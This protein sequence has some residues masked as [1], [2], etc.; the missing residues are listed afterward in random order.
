[1]IRYLATR[2]ISACLALFPIGAS[3]LSL[4]LDGAELPSGHFSL[5]AAP[6]ETIAL[7][8][9]ADIEQT[10][11]LLDG[12]DAGRR[13]AAQ[14]QVVA[15]VEPGIYALVIDHLSSSERRELSLYVGRPASDIRDGQVG[16]YVIGPEPAAHP[17][18]DYAH[19]YSAPEAFFEVSEEGADLAISE[20]FTLGQFLCKQ[21]SGYPKYLVLDSAL[22]ILLEGI[23]EELQRLGYPVRSLGMISAYRTPYYNRRIGNIPNSRHVYGDAFDF[24]V[25]VDGDGRMDDING[26]G[27]SNAGDVDHL[28]RIVTELKARPRYSTLVGG[29][30]RYYPNRHHGGY[31]HVD[32]RGF[33]ARW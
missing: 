27:L 19:F 15:P 24:Y 5:F 18:P 16:D 6:G 17:H 10:R 20:H 9:P 21:A 4:A 23:V 26:D 13:D 25:D 22:L 32:T 7:T 30:G 11:L 28:Y 33:R 3:G 29:V 12:R 1:M 2:M 14:W 31:I 8:L